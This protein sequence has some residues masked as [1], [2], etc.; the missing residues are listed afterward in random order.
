ME[1]RFGIPV[2]FQRDLFLQ[3]EPEAGEDGCEFIRRV[4]D[5]RVRLGFSHREALVK[6]WG[7]LPASILEYL[8][9]K[10]EMMGLGPIEWEHLVAYSKR[11]LDKWMST[12]ANK[13]LL[14]AATA[15]ATRHVAPAAPRAS[16]TPPPARTTQVH[17][18]VCEHAC[19]HEV[20][21]PIDA[22]LPHLAGHFQHVDD[23]IL[24]DLRYTPPYLGLVAKA[25]LHLQGQVAK[26][27]E[28]LGEK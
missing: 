9:S 16:P 4:E 7:N 23:G 2:E 26:L 11:Q 1:D 13:K 21:E 3:I 18:H 5:T 20:E 27:S 6:V 15:A 12:S 24:G 10:H 14:P 25:M 19:S 8:E 17:A 28:L 22:E